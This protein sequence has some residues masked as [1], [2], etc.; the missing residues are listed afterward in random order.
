MRGAAVGVA[1]ALDVVGAL[2]DPVVS[3]RGR[4]GPVALGAVPEAAID[5]DGDHRGPEDHVRAAAQAFEGWRGDAVAEPA[6]VEA[7]PDRDLRG[8]VAG[9]VGPHDVAPRRRRRPPSDG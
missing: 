8:G 5:E 3:V 9:A 4:D 1:V 6:R 7:L 2:R